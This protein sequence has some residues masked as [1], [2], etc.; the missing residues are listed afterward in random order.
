M[1]RRSLTGPLL[2][3]IVGSLFLWKNLHPE[4]NIFDLVALYWPFLL[5]GWG[6]LRLGETLI[7]NH[8]G[9]RS[10][11]SGG[12]IALIVIICIAGS[13]F[14]QAHRS[15]WRITA[16]GLDIWGQEFNYPVGDAADADKPILLSAAG[17]KRIVL[18]NPR[19]NV[20]IL[21]TASD[22]AQ[23]TGRKLVRAYSR[24]D[25]D[26]ANAGSAV[27]VTPEGD[28]LVVRVNSNDSARN[29]RVTVDLDISI[30]RGMIVE[31]HAV[32]G[33][34]EIDGV[35]GDVDVTIDRGDVRLSRLD[36]NAHLA[37]EQSSLI[38]A[39]AIKGNLDLN[40]NGS[41]LEVEDVGGQVTVT[42]SFDGNLGFKGIAKPL[43]YTGTRNTEVHVQAV[44]GVIS[45]DLSRMSGKDLVG[46]IRLM[47]ASRD[48]NIEKFTT[49]LEL[50]TQRGDIELTP[51]NTPLPAIDARSSNGRIELVLPA[52]ANFVLDA[53]AEIGDAV[54]DFGPAIRKDTS[55]RSATLTGRVG[56]GP[57]VRLNARR[58]WI[59]VRKE[60]SPSS[61]PRHEDEDTEK[62]KGT[63]L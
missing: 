55:G 51:G 23:V 11:L 40:C 63:D 1:R 60:G 13:G 30:P 2:L 26:R 53:T 46:P 50:E 44:P 4:S 57:T 35:A 20:K 32:T 6:V 39:N 9:Y 12:E 43:L 52:K 36:G 54:N 48:V 34:Y 15:G 47:T 16:E 56:E 41:D 33:D 42:G 10:G 31:S 59:S 37:V 38:R 18:D 62:S 19:G 45:M 21:G 14:V 27:V 7:W 24:Q 25:A 17:I 22:Q 49:S 3:L 61:L 8:Q 28:R 29:R 5:I 58:G